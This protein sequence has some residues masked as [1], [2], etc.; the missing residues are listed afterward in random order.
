MNAFIDLF[1]FSKFSSVLKAWCDEKMIYTYYDTPLGVIFKEC[2]PFLQ[3]LTIS[4]KSQALGSFFN[5][6]AWSLQIKE[7]IKIAV[8]LQETTVLC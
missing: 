6:V 2:F 4:W 3:E 1:F 7:A 8:L 5:V